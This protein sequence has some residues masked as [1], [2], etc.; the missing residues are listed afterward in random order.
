MSPQGPGGP[1]RKKVVG[2]GMA[3]FVRESG[4]GNGVHC[5][6]QGHAF[7]M[8]RKTERNVLSEHVY[9]ARESASL[10]KKKTLNRK[11]D[12]LQ[13]FVPTLNND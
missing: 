13:R 6:L 9:P 5:C 8:S 1:R 10:I 11:H 12:L 4:T 2:R 7:S 3:A